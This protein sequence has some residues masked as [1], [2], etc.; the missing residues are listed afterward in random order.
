MKGV[1]LRGTPLYL[2]AQVR[3]IDHR[4]RKEEMEWA[5]TPV[6]PI[7]RSLTSPSP[8]PSTVHSRRHLL[9]PVRSTR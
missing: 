9:I 2:D 4:L 8:F 1:T 7:I 6:V 5:V 3:E